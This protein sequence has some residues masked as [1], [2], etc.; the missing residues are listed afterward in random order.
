MNTTFVTRLPV[1]SYLTTDYNDKCS[2]KNKF[3]RWFC[4]CC[5]VDSKKGWQTLCLPVKYILLIHVMWS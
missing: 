4:F 5:F 3:Q 2:D 1:Q